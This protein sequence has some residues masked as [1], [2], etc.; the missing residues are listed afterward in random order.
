MYNISNNS[1]EMGR[2]GVPE[3]RGTVICLEE[4]I[5]DCDDQDP[6]TTQNANRFQFAVSFQLH[7]GIIGLLAKRL[8]T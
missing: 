8:I 1:L 6:E 2:Q 4:T 5:A 3:M 7:L